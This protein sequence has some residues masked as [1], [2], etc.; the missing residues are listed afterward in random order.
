[1]LSKEATT[2]FI[3]RCAMIII[4]LI[5]LV[6]VAITTEVI[7]AP[8]F[9]SLLFALLLLPVANFLERKLSVP[10]AA[11]ALLAVVILIAFLASIFYLLGSQVAHLAYG[12]PS[13]KEQLHAS[14]NDLQSSFAERFHIDIKKQ[15]SYVDKLASNAMSSG[16][17][18]GAT[19]LSLSTKL[20]FPLLSA[21]FTFFLLL[22]RRLLLTFLF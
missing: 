10:R 4:I 18:E 1:M 15:I 13:L 7:L 21:F 5:A 6:Y 17:V 16:T 12:Q 19:V 20:L 8:L 11:A 22:Y 3:I 14:L 9:L 2:L